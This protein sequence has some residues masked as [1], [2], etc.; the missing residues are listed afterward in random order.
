M[1]TEDMES[2]A[3]EMD[4]AESKHIVIKGGAKQKPGIRRE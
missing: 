4:K 3:E 1:R 2:I